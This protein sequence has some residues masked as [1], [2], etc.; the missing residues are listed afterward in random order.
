M[1]LNLSKNGRQIQ[2]GAAEEPTT[3]MS[4]LLD[5]PVSTLLRK[6][7]SSNITVNDLPDLNTDQLSTE[8]MSGYKWSEDRLNCFYITKSSERRVIFS[9]LLKF[10]KPFV[11]AFAIRVAAIFSDYASILLLKYLIDSAEISSSLFTFFV[12]SALILLFMQIRSILLG[13]LRVNFG[14][15]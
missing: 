2:E 15:L 11:Y 9:V 10:W 13:N 1:T 3:F 4:K 8:L 14:K 6:C 7:K 5:L 12:I